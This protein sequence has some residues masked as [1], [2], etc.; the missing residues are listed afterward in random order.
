M[1]ERRFHRHRGLRIRKKRDFS[2]LGE[3]VNEP[4]EYGSLFEI[5]ELIP[6]LILA[7]KCVTG[8]FINVTWPRLLVPT[9]PHFG[10][11][12]INAET[13]KPKEET[14]TNPTAMESVFSNQV[15]YL[16]CSEIEIEA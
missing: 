9:R 4:P 11:D 5:I 7:P 12:F 3:A 16:F 2:D 14:I 13:L 15:H 8:R 1:K 10:Q 6:P